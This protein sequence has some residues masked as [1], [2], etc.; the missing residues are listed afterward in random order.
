MGK[1]SWTID[2]L[3]HE[4]GVSRATIH[5]YVTKGLLPRPDGYGRGASYNNLHFNRLAEIRR[6][7]DKRVTLRDLADRYA[8]PR[9]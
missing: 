4:F 7:M 9:D 8:Q 5:R 2:E 6:E 3:V 1:T